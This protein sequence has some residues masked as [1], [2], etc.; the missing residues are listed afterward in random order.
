MFDFEVTD[1]DR[2]RIAALPKDLRTADTRWAPD[3]TS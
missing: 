1:S 3:W 2:E